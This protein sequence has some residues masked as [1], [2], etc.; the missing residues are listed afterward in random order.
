MAIAKSDGNGG[1]IFSKRN[2]VMLSVALTIIG[3]LL[4]IAVAWGSMT[5]AF[6]DH[7]ADTNIHWNKTALDDAYVPRP[8]V[9]A[10]L[11][12]IGDQLDRIEVMV[13]EFTH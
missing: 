11:K 2:L 13:G 7:S 8:E 10:E 6:A 4:G 9:Q 3:I 1:Y 12:A 5:Q